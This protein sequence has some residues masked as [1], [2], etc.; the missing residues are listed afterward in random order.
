MIP[1]TKHFEITRTERGYSIDFSTEAGSEGELTLS[2]DEAMEL[3]LLL[4]HQLA[5]VLLE[6]NY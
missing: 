1:T 3:H 5:E 4:G 2:A 6:N